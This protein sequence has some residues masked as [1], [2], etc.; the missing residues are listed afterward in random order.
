MHRKRSLLCQI[1]LFAF[2]ICEHTWLTKLVCNS[3][4]ST[5]G[6]RPLDYQR[7]KTRRIA[8]DPELG[9]VVLEVCQGPKPQERERR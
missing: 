3:T 4:P 5:E 1:V 7:T 8:P 6:I 9:D 2:G